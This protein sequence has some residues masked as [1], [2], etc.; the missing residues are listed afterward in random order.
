M[1]NVQSWQA[2]VASLLQCEIYYIKKCLFINKIFRNSVTANLLF[3]NTAKLLQES[4]HEIFSF[5]FASPEA[6][7]RYT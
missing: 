5:A 1:Q 4:T 2:F 6:I 7:D 3:V